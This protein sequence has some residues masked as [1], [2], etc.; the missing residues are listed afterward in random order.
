MKLRPFNGSSAICVC[1]TTPP[2]TALLN[3]TLVAAPCT[4]TCSLT[5]PTFIVRSATMSRPISTVRL[6]RRA[7]PN[8]GSSALTT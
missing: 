1:D 7:G 5:P 3:S 2:A 4:V 8:P 6:S